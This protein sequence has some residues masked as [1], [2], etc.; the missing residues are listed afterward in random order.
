MRIDSALGAID[1]AGN[2]EVHPNTGGNPVCT[3]QTIGE[4]ATVSYDTSH[5][6]GGGIRVTIPFLPIFLN[7]TLKANF[8]CEV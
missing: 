1:S 4:D 6:P 5:L 3:A 8:R 2:V 7:P